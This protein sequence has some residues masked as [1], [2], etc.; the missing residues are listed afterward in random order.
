MWQQKLIYGNFLKFFIATHS[1][2]EE[3]LHNWSGVRLDT[4]G[5]SSDKKSKRRI[6]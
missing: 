6:S 1:I 4:L 2:E 3:K 5:T